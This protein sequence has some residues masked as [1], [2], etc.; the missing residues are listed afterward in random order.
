MS[1]SAPPS[2]PLP[3]ADLA[4]ASERLAGTQSR[5]EKKAILVELLGRTPPAEVAQAVGWLVAEPSCG[6]LGVG[7]AQLWKLSDMPAAPAPAVTL[8]QV[9]EAL[10]AGSSRGGGAEREDVAARVA[11]IFSRLTGAERDLFMGAL[12]GSLRQGSLGGVMT[13]AIA[14]LAGHPESVVRRAVMVKGSIAAAADALLGSGRGA[15]PPSALELFRPVAPMLALHADSIEE[16]LDG[17]GEPEVEWKVDGVRAQL[18][19]DGERVAAY[20]RRGNEIT[21]GCAPLLDSFRALSAERVV[22]D[23]EIVVVG[24]DGRARA[25]Q[26]SFSSLA[27]GGTLGEGDRLRAFFFDCLHRDGEDLVDRPL[28]DRL[29]ALEAVTPPQLRMPRREGATAETATRFY[30]EAQAA[31]HE[32]IVVKDLASPYQMSARG[33]AWRK[34]KPFVTVDLVVLAVEW[35]SGRREGFLSNLHLGARRADG[36]FCM[37]GKTFKGLTDALLEWQTAHLLGLKT[38]EKRRVVWVRPELVVEIR[39]NDVQRSPRYPGGIALRFARVVRY[40]ED[41]KPEEA[42]TLESLVA[43]S[44]AAVVK[45]G[46]KASG[47]SKASGGGRGTGAKRA[48]K[49]TGEAEAEA[50]AG[51]KRKQLSLFDD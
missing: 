44:P 36:T 35:G 26:D 5:L 34:V 31:G 18:H 41:K 13:T 51:K 2:A 10:G 11:S 16:S 14:E 19:K 42:D 43:R 6:P 49:K 4:S 23:G 37:V 46:R 39:F 50:E 12:T 45:P 28:R 20:S 24:P 48:A 29:A 17:M 32:G 27:S 22:L 3:F 7:P 9:E 25:F 47:A 15:A 40:R 21:S 8:A 30:E 33:G 38:E 1:P